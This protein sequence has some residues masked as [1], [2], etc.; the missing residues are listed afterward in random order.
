MG[1]FSYLISQVLPL[2]NIIISQFIDTQEI[3]YDP[4]SKMLVSTKHFSIS[5]YICI[6]CYA[7]LACTHIYTRLASAKYYSTT[8]KQL[9]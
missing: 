6:P 1:F 7:T 4:S 9:I 5:A 3:L 2:V 8:T